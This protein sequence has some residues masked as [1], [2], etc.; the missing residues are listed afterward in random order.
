MKTDMKRWFWMKA[1]V[2]V[3]LVCAAVT[4]IP[5]S[6]Q[7]TAP[8]QIELKAQSMDAALA[9]VGETF[10]V[11]VIASGESVRGLTA[12]AISGVLTAEETLVQLL[13]NTSLEVV[14]NDNGNF[15]IR[16]S[17]STPDPQEA[18]S[19]KNPATTVTEEI[20][21]TARK[22]GTQSYRADTSAIGTKT[23][24]PLIE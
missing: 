10:G 15:L 20:I 7:A 3:M 21:V 17:P 14:A 1:L 9:E 24:T 23:D 5:V 22:L 19:S 6:A 13:E 12:P 16:S 11:S 8:R 4:A 2:S 18:A